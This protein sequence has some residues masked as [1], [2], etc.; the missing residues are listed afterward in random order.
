MHQRGTPNDIA[1]LVR[2]DPTNEMPAF[3]VEQLLALLEQG[4]AI[5][6]K[7]MDSRSDSLGYLRRTNRLAHGDDSDFFRAPINACASRNHRL[8]DGSMVL[9]DTGYG[10]RTPV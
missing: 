5:L 7:I 3:G 6:T 2:L 8:E 4:G 1:D 9:S 10:S